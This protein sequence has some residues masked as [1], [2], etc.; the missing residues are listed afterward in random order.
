MRKQ[1]QVQ[2]RCDAYGNEPITIEWYKNKQ[3]LTNDL[4]SRYS[5][6]NSPRQNE[7]ISLLIIKQAQRQDN[8]LY[9]CVT[10]NQVGKD[11][12]PIELNV[13]EEPDSI[14]ELQTT[15][16]NTRSV[17]LMWTEPYDGRSSITSYM[18]QYKKVQPTSHDSLAVFMGQS[19]SM[20]SDFDLVPAQQQDS[21]SAD[22][23][24]SLSAKSS[25]ADDWQQAS[26]IN[27]PVT[28][29]GNNVTVRS[30]TIEKL[31]PST[32]YVLR[33][34]AT[35][36][37]GQ[38]KFSQ[39]MEFFTEE[40]APEAGPVN[41]RA[42][43]I[44]STSILVSWDELPKSRQPVRIHGYYIGYRTASSTN[45][46][47][48]LVAQPNFIYK[49]YI[50]NE[51]SAGHS[52]AAYATEQSSRLEYVI[53]DLRRDTNY[54]ITVVAF[55]ARGSSPSSDFVF[56]KTIEMEA[57]KP[58]KLSVRRESNDS[59]FIEWA[60]D[61]SDQ[62][63]VDDYTLYQEKNSASQDTVW[64][65]QRFPGN[66]TQYKAPG[67]KCGTRYQ[68]Y[69]IAHNKVGK[70]LPSE[71]I[72][73]ST[74]GNL[75]VIPSKMNLIKMIN[76]TCLLINLNS[77]QDNGCRIKTFT[78]RYRAEK[79]GL[80]KSS[81]NHSVSSNGL[82][83][84]THMALA[85]SS[86]QAPK[87]AN[88]VQTLAAS[89]QHQPQQA[90]SD[91]TTIRPEEDRLEYLCDLSPTGEYTI[92]VTATN[93]V[94]RSEIEYTVLMSSDELRYSFLRDVI[95]VVSG[96]PNVFA[97]IPSILVFLLSG[98]FVSLTG[99]I[100]YT[101]ISK[102]YQKFVIMHNQIR[103]TR[104]AKHD[105]KRRRKLNNSRHSQK[106]D[107]WA[108]E[109]DEDDDGDD[110]ANGSNE[111][112]NQDDM[113]ADG[114]DEEDEMTTIDNNSSCSSRSNHRSHHSRQHS[115]MAHSHNHLQFIS[116][117][118]PNGHYLSN[119]GA[120][121][122]DASSIDSGRCQKQFNNC[123]Q[124]SA[125]TSPD[126]IHGRF[127]C[128]NSK[129]YVKMNEYTM[130]PTISA[131]LNSSPHNTGIYGTTANTTNINPPQAS[132]PN[133]MSS[134]QD[135]S[136]NSLYYSTLRRSNMQTYLPQQRR[137][138]SHL[139]HI[140][141]HQHQ[142]RRSQ[143]IADIYGYYMAPPQLAGNGQ[144]PPAQG[145]PQQVVANDEAANSIFVPPQQIIYSAP[146]IRR[147]PVFL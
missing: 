123:H 46:N 7:L 144:A 71:V 142:N 34:L 90:T 4:D 45:I 65:Q 112:L 120:T 50:V 119:L 44:N 21:P 12:L 68:F 18:F 69:I 127:Q 114:D 60:R 19:S 107:L 61:Q 104:R 62:N 8:S 128:L 5:I 79:I 32:K 96:L 117:S 130:L 132:Q 30:L 26:R 28:P 77:F 9:E 2:L 99:L 51:L 95:E 72:S 64:L 101:T 22:L 14:Q 126:S 41:I 29:S 80:P 35:N 59:I 100:L 24:S 97:Y 57:P 137:S 86:H 11:R 134:S 40:E 106:L 13:Q 52:Q 109:Y 85:A 16:I 74:S 116:N 36:A 67:L 54:E 23:A 146:N 133:P 136:N 84:A 93:D 94:G 33:A 143:N 15:Q 6:H 135:S 25:P 43:A 89:S 115:N 56:C 47:T 105:E 91:W 138:Q 124:M 1:N 131:T 87:Q 58:V 49:P 88:H 27:M 110:E 48:S 10:R 75:P 129:Q 139:Q 20:M 38:S 102:Y 122:F 140:Q 55:N 103:A 53:H 37:I 3:R 113:E 121:N 78:V 31:D 82:I 83:G 63:P 66:Q 111:I 92:H 17:T 108:D 42:S 76:S 141:Q 81:L 145:N 70:S 73:A 98:L 118:S 39:P 147:P 125:T